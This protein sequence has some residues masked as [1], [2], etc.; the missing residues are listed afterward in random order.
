MS[1]TLDP[2]MDRQ[3]LVPALGMAL[4]GSQ[5]VTPDTAGHWQAA[6]EGR[7]SVPTCS[8]C[9]THYWPVVHA[10]YACCSLEWSWQPVAGTGKVYTYTWVDAP[11][12]PAAELDNLAVIELDGISGE[13]VRVPGWVVGVDKATLVCGL[14]VEAD[15]QPVADAVSVPFWRPR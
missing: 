3:I 2:A 15:F 14:A 5:P 4:M 1:S 7:F 8:S 11:T 9:G 6:S 12:H 10:C 13:P